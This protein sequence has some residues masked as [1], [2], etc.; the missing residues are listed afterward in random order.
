MRSGCQ[1][2][3]L[4]IILISV[5]SS[6]LVVGAFAIWLY[7]VGFDDM[8]RRAREDWLKRSVDEGMKDMIASL[9]KDVFTG[10]F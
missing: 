7:Y 3:L 8:Y 5:S 10:P 6:A 1:V 9:E 4:G 2:T